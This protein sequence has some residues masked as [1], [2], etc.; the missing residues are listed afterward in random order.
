[1]VGVPVPLGRQQAGPA[2]A[3]QAAAEQED[4]GFLAGLQDPQ[5]GVDRSQVSDEQDG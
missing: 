2:A 1:V 3:G 4:V 5:L